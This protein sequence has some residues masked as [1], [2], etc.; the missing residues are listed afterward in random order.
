MNNTINQTPNE[1]S[2]ETGWVTYQ[3]SNPYNCR[4]WE[5]SNGLMA[6]SQTNRESASPTLSSQRPQTPP[7]KDVAPQDDDKYELIPDLPQQDGSSEYPIIID[8]GV[9][10]LL[11]SISALHEA[12]NALEHHVKDPVTHMLFTNPYIATDGHTYDLNIIE[13]CET[14]PLMRESPFNKV[15]PNLYAK[16]TVDI[17]TTLAKEYKSKIEQFKKVV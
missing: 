9:G 11:A 10:D 1:P 3:P 14:S 2:D 13:K 5:Q 4:L 8:D 12:L 6:V 16:Q 17:Y 7:T 15:C